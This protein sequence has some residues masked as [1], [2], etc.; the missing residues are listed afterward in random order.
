[1][2]ELMKYAMPVYSPAETGFS[3]AS[4]LSPCSS[5]AI[6]LASRLGSWTISPAMRSA[7][8]SRYPFLAMSDLILFMKSWDAY[9]AA[10]LTLP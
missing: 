4:S 5:S 3:I 7:A 2:S 10:S 6:V 1:M 9:L 8:Y